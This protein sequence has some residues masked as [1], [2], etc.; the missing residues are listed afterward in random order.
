MKRSRMRRQKAPKSA[1][2]M[3]MV[4]DRSGASI[5]RP[6]PPSPPGPTAPRRRRHN[7]WLPRVSCPQDTHAN[8]PGAGL[9]VSGGE[10]G[11]RVDRRLAVL[12]DCHAFR[13]TDAFVD[14]LAEGAEAV[15]SGTQ[16][17][18]ATADTTCG[19]PSCR[20]GVSGSRS[21][22]SS[23]RNAFSALAGM[24]APVARR[25]THAS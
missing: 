18:T 6:R 15:K 21:V 9:S 24:T 16:N 7:V 14:I 3:A 1:S 17:S 10:V 22:L 25:T 23:R 11:E 13:P 5:L 12:P 20:A 8:L 19:Q 4:L 2:L